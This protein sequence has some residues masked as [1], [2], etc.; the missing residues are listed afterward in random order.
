MVSRYVDSGA[1]AH[2]FTFDFARNPTRLPSKLGRIR[3]LVEAVDPD[4][5]HMHNVGPTL[6]TRLALGKHHTV[7]RVFQVPGPLHLEHLAYRRGELATAGPNDSWI[8]ASEY[9]RG[10]YLSAGIDWRRVSVSYYGTDV[11]DF[12]PS[13]NPLDLRAEIGIGEATRVIGMV[14]YMY[15]PKRYLGQTKGLKGHEDLIEATAIGL[16]K[17]ADLAVVFVGGAWNGATAYERHLRAL[18]ARRCGDRAFFLG[19][20]SDI[21]DLYANFDVSVQPS[22]SENV[23]SALESLLC[24]VPT[25]SSNVGGFPELVKEGQ[26]GWLVAPRDPRALWQ[27][28]SDALADRTHA[29]V[30]ADAGRRLARHLFD[31]KRTSA[32]VEDIY[33][34]IMNPS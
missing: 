31:I 16:S 18:A 14:A 9:T 24:G 11:D 19:T 22:L 12:A 17:G 21:S 26:T 29:R 20:R 10:L 7:P 34:R 1:I 25:I 4:V 15:P 6:M 2:P 3:H 32:E 13:A 8:A 5:I 23:G 27:A 30:L 28:I 33:S